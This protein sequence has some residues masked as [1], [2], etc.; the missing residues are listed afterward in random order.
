MEGRPQTSPKQD[1]VLAQGQSSTECQR[2]KSDFYLSL[3]TW[4]STLRTNFPEKE[5]IERSFHLNHIKFYY[6]ILLNYLPYLY[7]LL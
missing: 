5:L 6:L 7:L 3:S 1:R 4:H 2:L